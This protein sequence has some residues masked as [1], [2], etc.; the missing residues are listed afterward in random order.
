VSGEETYNQAK[1]VLTD[2]RKTLI[3]DMVGERVKALL[4][5]RHDAMDKYKS[6]IEN[7]DVEFGLLYALHRYALYVRLK[8]RGLGAGYKAVV[9]SR[10]VGDTSLYPTEP[11]YNVPQRSLPTVPIFKFTPKTTVDVFESTF[12][13][14]AT[15]AFMIECP[16]NMFL[17]TPDVTNVFSDFYLLYPQFKRRGRWELNS[18]FNPELHQFEG[19]LLRLS[20]LLTYSGD[21]NHYN[22]GVNVWWEASSFDSD[23]KP[24]P[25][26]AFVRVIGSDSLPETVKYNIVGHRIPQTD[27]R[28]YL[29]GVRTYTFTGFMPCAVGYSEIM[30]NPPVEVWRNI[31][32]VKVEVNDESMGYTDPPVGEYDVNAS[33]PFT[34]TAYPYDGYALDYWEVDGVNWGD[35]NPLT[36]QPVTKP[37]T[38]KAIFKEV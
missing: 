14:N 16:H 10:Y 20:R 15:S 27:Q 37:L 25:Q 32:R 4:D 8:G 36:I 19:E 34:V 6:L 3:N 12:E 38:V 17:E 24:T 30:G 13:G 23:G 5:A 18:P 28:M 31:F 21:N 7:L 11:P 26:P 22:L 33:D 1:Q 9:S 29:L 2:F 35:A